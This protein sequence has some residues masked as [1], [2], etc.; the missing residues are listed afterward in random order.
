VGTDEAIHWPMAISAHM[1]LEGGPLLQL[2]L[3]EMLLQSYSGTLRVFPAVTPDWEGRFRLH[4]V[5]GFVVSSARAPGNTTFVV[6][7]SRAG[8]VC[9]LANPWPMSAAVVYRE[10]GGWVRLA[11]LNGDVLTFPTQAGAVFLV[12]PGGVEPGA[13][14]PTTFGGRMNAGPK[15]LGRARLGIGKGF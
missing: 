7:E 8:D 15:A 2:A 6:I 9:R 12:L 14:K 3:S 10:A 5:G 1:S 4:A 13:L 11:E